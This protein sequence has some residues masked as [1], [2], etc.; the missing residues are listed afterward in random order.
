M[1]Y[2]VSI[3]VFII[4]FSVL[5]L[6]HEFGHFF[7]AR[8]FGVKVDEFGMGLPP[9]MKGLWKDKSGTLYSLNWIPFGGFVRMYGEDSEDPALRYK[10]GSFA[11]KSVGARTII[12]L[13][14]VLM[15]FLLG[16]VLLVLLFTAGTKPFIVNQEDYQYY[17]DQGIVVAEEH[18]LVTDFSDQSTAK[19]AGLQKNDEL[20]SVN[21]VSVDGNEEV[22]AALKAIANQE[23]TIGVIR[24]DKELSFTV[25]INAEGRMGVVIA[26]APEIKEVKEIT[27]P[28]H[29]A[30][31]SAGY[32][33]GR[34]SWLTMKL[35]VQ[36]IVDLFTKFELSPSVSGP[37]GIAQIT[38]QTTQTGNFFDILKL[39]ALL[40]IS[41]GAINVIP[42][43]AL[44]GGRFLSIIFEVVTRRRP[45]AAWEARIH[46][47]GFLII[48]ILI[49][50]VTFNDITKLFA[51]N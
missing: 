13:G 28:F 1:G 37:V 17:K 5:I 32:E 6:I 16:Y 47:F 15:N 14:G 9:R 49:V 24:D 2:L 7:A 20:V 38:H 50:A 12:I 43:P 48:L 27:L 25:P 30:L 42:I 34:L 22:I 39:V 31:V 18:V 29:K 26:D 4:I 10:E 46:A 11:S 41:L 36:V 21:G 40:S 33:T 19:E 23:A 3:V 51:A 45:N 8:K 44:D 35:F